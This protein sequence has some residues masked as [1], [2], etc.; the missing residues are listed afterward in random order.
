MGPGHLGSVLFRMLVNTL[1]KSL[2]CVRVPPP[3]AHQCSGGSAM[4]GQ[5]QTGVRHDLVISSPLPRFLRPPST[6]NIQ[7]TRVDEFI[8]I[9]ISALL[10]CV[11]SLSQS[12]QHPTEY[13]LCLRHVYQNDLNKEQKSLCTQAS[14]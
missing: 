10:G 11:L 5:K 2:P 4:Y 6:A 9:H 12:P 14:C 1:K 7:H 13:N 3:P 8:P